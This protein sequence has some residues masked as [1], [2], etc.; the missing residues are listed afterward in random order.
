MTGIEPW[1]SGIGSNCSTNWDTTTARCCV[2]WL[3]NKCKQES[4]L[5]SPA[6]PSHFPVLG[7]YIPWLWNRLKVGTKLYIFISAE[8]M[9]PLEPSGKPLSSYKIF[10]SLSL[11]MYG[12]VPRRPMLTGSPWRTWGHCLNEASLIL[13]SS[14]LNPSSSGFSFKVS[15]ICAS[16]CFSVGQNRWIVTPSSLPILYTFFLLI[17][18]Q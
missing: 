6:P 4:R 12:L 1:T 10:L 2:L 5:T 11:Y 17:F 7:L 15:R 16:D 13:T 14:R 18:K 8:D 3:E 9:P